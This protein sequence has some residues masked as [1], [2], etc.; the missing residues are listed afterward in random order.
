MKKHLKIKMIQH[1][2]MKSFFHI[3]KSG[4]AKQMLS[5]KTK[6][7][8]VSSLC[9]VMNTYNCCL[10]ILKNGM[11]IL[12]Q[13]E[14]Q[15]LVSIFIIFINIYIIFSKHQFQIIEFTRLA[16]ILTQIVTNHDEVIERKGKDDF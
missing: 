8:I 7:Q 13:L 2:A 10:T 12:E 1:Y 6:K 5:M 4:E 3:V 11:L 15:S 9:D 14:I 16:K